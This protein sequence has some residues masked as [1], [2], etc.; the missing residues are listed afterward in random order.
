MAETVFTPDTVFSTATRQVRIFPCPAAEFRVQ[1]TK[2]QLRIFD[3]EGLD[4]RSAKVQ[5]VIREIIIDRLRREAIDDLPA[6][7]A[8]LA[9]AHGFSYTGVTI[10][11]LRSRWGSC[12]STNHLNLN[13]YLMRLPEDL[14]D[15]VILHELAHT[16]HKNHGAGFWQCLD[17]LVHGQ[18]KALT[19]RMRQYN[20]WL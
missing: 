9:A 5:M 20:V 1:T 13:L 6:R 4:L 12:S 10:K 3:P 11:R 17:R 18:A 19:A 2:E 16:V 7:T 14:R 15:Y 8:R